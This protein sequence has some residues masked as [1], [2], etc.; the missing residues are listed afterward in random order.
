MVGCLHFLGVLRLSN[1]PP[2]TATVEIINLPPP[3]VAT[4]GRRDQV[5]LQHI[6]PVTTLLKL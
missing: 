4:P 5:A 1:T 2:P 6:H 3:S